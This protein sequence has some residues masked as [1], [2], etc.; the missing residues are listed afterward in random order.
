MLG[1]RSGRGYFGR[2]EIVLKINFNFERIFN[3]DEIVL[4]GK[5]LSRFN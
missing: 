3:L 5:R 2:K 1:G 4:N